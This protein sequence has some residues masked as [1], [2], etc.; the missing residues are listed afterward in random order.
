MT[1]DQFEP[2]W[3]NCIMEME[4]VGMSQNSTMLYM[5]YLQRLDSHQRLEVQQAYRNFPRDDGGV[6]L[7][8]ARTWEE[9]HEVCRELENIKAGWKAINSSFPTRSRPKEMKG[10]DQGERLAKPEKQR[11]DGGGKEPTLVAATAGGPPPRRKVC[12]QMRDE[13]ACKYGRDCKFSHDPKDIKEAKERKRGNL[14]QAAVQETVAKG[15]SSKGRGKGGRGK[16]CRANSPGGRSD[17]SGASGSSASKVP[18]GV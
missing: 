12:W 10:H 13:G 1:A 6:E 8:R 11:K 15:S 18:K 4:L 7:R 9:L 17:K 14:S 16:G 3:Q 5:G 2:L